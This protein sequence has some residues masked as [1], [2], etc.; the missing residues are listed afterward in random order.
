MA[1]I[2]NNSRQNLFNALTEKKLS[3][4]TFEEFNQKMDIPESRR[5]LFDAVSSRGF[6]IGTFEEFEGRWDHS[7]LW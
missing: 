3:L 7:Q 1:D 5:K 2:D 4:G 6:N